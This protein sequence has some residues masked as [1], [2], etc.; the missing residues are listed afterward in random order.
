M[1]GIQSK[2]AEVLG[3]PFFQSVGKPITNSVK[4]IGS[5]PAALHNYNSSKWENC[6]LMARNTLFRGVQSKSWKR[7][8]QWGPIAD[9]LRPAI[10]QFVDDLILKASIADNFGESVK[11]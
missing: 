10:I 3:Y 9:E 5:W 11:A 4:I 6:C 8:Q 1:P 7:A 2:L